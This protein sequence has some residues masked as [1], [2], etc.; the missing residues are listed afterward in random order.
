MSGFTVGGRRGGGGGG[1]VKLLLSGSSRSGWT[2]DS[3]TSLASSFSNSSHIDEEHSLDQARG[4]DKVN[5]TRFLQEL[6]KLVG[7]TNS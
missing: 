1:E 4:G 2:Q 5:R 7:G 6:P 3:I